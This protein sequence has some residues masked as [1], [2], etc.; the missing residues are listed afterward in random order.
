[1][2]RRAGRQDEAMADKAVPHFHNEPG[3]A[4]IHVGPLQRLFDVTSISL[5]QWGVCVAVA[6]SVLVVEELRKVFMRRRPVGA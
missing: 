4:V 1:M 2:A 5:A 3:V 6:S